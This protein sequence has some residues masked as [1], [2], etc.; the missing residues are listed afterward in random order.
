MLILR[1]PHSWKCSLWKIHVLGYARLGKG[2]FWSGRVFESD[3]FGP[4]H[5]LG[6]ARSE[7][8][9][10]FW[11]LCVRR[12]VKYYIWLSPE[13]SSVGFCYCQDYPDFPSEQFTDFVI[14]LLSVFELVLL[15]CLCEWGN[16]LAGKQWKYKLYNYIW[17]NIMPKIIKTK[18]M[19][20]L[21]QISS[22][23]IFAAF[24]T[25]ICNF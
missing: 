8:N 18:A 25:L 21:L 5:I 13:L 10:T 3:R 20:R 22:S 23:Y 16:K 1:R 4:V 11:L 9:P 12:I 2:S 24:G 19:L 6:S 7:P 15:Y 14:I 17:N